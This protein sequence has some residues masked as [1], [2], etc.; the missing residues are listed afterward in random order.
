MS[1]GPKPP[2]APK[3]RLTGP[4]EYL[5]NSLGKC[6]NGR[7]LCEDRGLYDGH[8][9][10]LNCL[11][12][13]PDEQYIMVPRAPQKE[14]T[15]VDGAT[16]EPGFEGEVQEHG[17][18]QTGTEGDLEAPDEEAPSRDSEEGMVHALEDEDCDH[19][20]ETDGTPTSPDEGAPS[21]D[22]EEVP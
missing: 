15:P 6:S 1:R 21:R 3:P 7:L 8:H 9:S 10:T 5:N 19:D 18:E 12:L 14:D 2:I 17:T 16:E 22:S 20:P 4:S 11:E 13:E